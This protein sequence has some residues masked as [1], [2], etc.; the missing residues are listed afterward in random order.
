MSADDRSQH[1][2]QCGKVGWCVWGAKDCP[3]REV[4]WWRP[5]ALAACSA[6]G[7]MRE[8]ARIWGRLFK[9]VFEAL[10]GG[11]KSKK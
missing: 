4:P 7:W 5:F 1:Q 8:E 6:A 11:T 9:A 2:E 3:A 10:F